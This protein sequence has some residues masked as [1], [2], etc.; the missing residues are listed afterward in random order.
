MSWPVYAGRDLSRYGNWRN[1]LGVF[2]TGMQPTYVGAYNHATE[3]GIARV[4]SPRVVAGLK[5]F[6]FGAEFPARSEYSDDGS[7]YFEMWS[8]PCR[9][10]WPEDDVLLEPGQ[11]LQWREVWLPF[12]QIGGLD[13]ANE[14]AAVRASVQGGQVE[15]GVAVSRAQRIQITLRWNGQAFRQEQ[16]SL[17]PDMPLLLQ[18]P[19]PDS[20]SSPGDLTVRVEPGSG[21]NTLEYTK[22]ITP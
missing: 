22:T 3:L 13:M 7:E 11:S 15:L 10:F 20:P 8:G 17:S 14:E 16:A 12:R 21:G 6:A 1:W 9:T 18:V 2:V 4:F 19:L 5:L